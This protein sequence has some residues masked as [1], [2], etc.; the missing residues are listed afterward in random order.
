MTR[1]DFQEIAEERLQDAEALLIAGR[2][3]GAYYV[4]GYAVECALKAVIAKRTV[5][6][7]F[8]AKDAA[9]LYTH[10]L[11]ELL[12]FAGLGTGN[13]AITTPGVSV[14]CTTLWETVK[15]WKEIARYES[16]NQQ[17]A[18]ELVAAIN[19]PTDGVLAWIRIHW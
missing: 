12:L 14:R 13:G 18:E 2:W 4:A 5:A 9:K 19:D 8:P 11:K 10:N 17:Q 3:S 7:D 1:T 6:D 15:Q 16:K